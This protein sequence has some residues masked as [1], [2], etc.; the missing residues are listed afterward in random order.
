MST[1]SKLKTMKWRKVSAPAP[2]R[3][4]DGDELVGYYVGRTSRDGIHGQYEVVVVAVPYKG[5]YMIS[6]TKIL[7]LTDAAMCARGDAVRVKFLGDIPIGKRGRTMKDF[8]LYVGELEHV[9]DL[10]EGE[11]PATA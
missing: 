11:T 9:D 2:W 10:P 5:A 7:Q 6:G 3:P 4:K 1:A 8:E